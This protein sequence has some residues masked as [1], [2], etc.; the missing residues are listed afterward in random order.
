MACDPPE[1]VCFVTGIEGERPDSRSQ[2][3]REIYMEIQECVHTKTHF[4]FSDLELRI[5]LKFEAIR[6]PV[7]PAMAPS[8]RG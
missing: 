8:V 7:L 1:D 4:L 2:L 5:D 6:F 3:L